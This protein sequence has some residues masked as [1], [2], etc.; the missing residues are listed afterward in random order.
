MRKYLNMKKGYCITLEFARTDGTILENILNQFW[1]IPTKCDR[2]GKLFRF[3]H[4]HRDKLAAIKTS[5]QR[6]YDDWCLD[7]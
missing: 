1:I 2:C 5:K 3:F 7:N 4:F 6:Y